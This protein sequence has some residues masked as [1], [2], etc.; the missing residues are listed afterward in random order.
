MKMSSY[1]GER[2]SEKVSNKIRE[3]IVVTGACGF[4]G[5]HLVNRLINYGLS[6]IAIDLNINRA[7]QLLTL[8]EADFT[9][10]ADLKIIEKKLNSPCYLV[11][12]GGYMFDKLTEIGEYNAQRSIDVN[13]SGTYNLIKVLKSRLSGVCLASTVDVYGAQQFL[14]INENSQTNPDTFYGASKLAMELYAKVELGREIPLAILRFS[15]IYGPGDTHKKV[16]TLF[17]EAVR[18]GKNPVI[19]GDGSDLRDYIHSNDIVEVI[20]R[21]ISTKAQ[22]IFNIATGKSYSLNELAKLVI[23]LSGRKLS[24]V[25]MPRQQRRKDYSFDIS[26]MKNELGFF[27]HVSIEQGVSELM[28][29]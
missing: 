29:L 18:S 27:P 11:H 3:T 1:K 16:L 4:V 7:Q 20:T 9:N 8:L 10:N 25:Y 6:V 23:K 19:Y 2:K 24:P 17:I 15:H 26:K 28:N 21:I 14:P 22:G 12:L 13:I 5:T